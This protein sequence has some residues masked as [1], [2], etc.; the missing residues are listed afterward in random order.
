[1]NTSNTK[2]SKIPTIRWEEEKNGDHDEDLFGE[3]PSEDGD[4]SEFA[5]LLALEKSS[6]KRPPSILVGQRIRGQVLLIRPDHNDVMVDLGG[7]KLTGV[8]GKAELLDPESGALIVKVGDPIEAFVVSKQGDEVLLSYKMN[9]ALKSLEDLEMAQAK[10]IPVKARVLKAVKGGFEVSVLGKVGFCPIS[11][12]DSR[13][14]EGGQ[15]YIGKEYEFIVEKVEGKGRNI[16][17]NRAA[18]LKLKAEEKTR[19]VVESLQKEP[20]KI[21]TGT[22]KE[23]RDFGAFIDLG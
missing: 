16:V 4:S 17:L 7:G 13:F 6:G 10:K 8:I 19:Q 9:A 11:K 2:S 22:V 15:E 23:L 3:N 18:L 12:I 5:N 21:W 20:E 14:V 1:M